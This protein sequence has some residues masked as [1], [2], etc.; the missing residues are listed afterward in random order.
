MFPGLPGAAPY[1]ASSPTSPPNF[2]GESKL[3]G[4]KAVLENGGVVLR[5]PVL[6]GETERN[7]ESAVNVLLDTVMN[8]D[9]KERV[10]MDDWSV[11]YPTNT[12]DVSRVVRDVV[13]KYLVEGG[14]EGGLPGVLQFS[15]EERMTKYG[16]CKMLAEIMGV[17]LEH[18][19]P[20]ANND[21]NAEGEWFL[22]WYWGGKANG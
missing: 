16:I 2:Y 21:E 10:E 14:R 3:A 17:G 13:G 20:N 7:K 12:E 15:A 19:V 6:Y 1:S 8:V 9:G 5:V 11:R 18:V 4:E 22:G